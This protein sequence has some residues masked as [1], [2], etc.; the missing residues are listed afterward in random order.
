MSR[1]FSDDLLIF[2]NNCITIAFTTQPKKK[3]LR[4]S[5]SRQPYLKAQSHTTCIG[6]GISGVSSVQNIM[7]AT[8]SD[9]Q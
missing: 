7:S 4:W 5:L 6:S 1:G 9:S 2:R 3:R 8:S